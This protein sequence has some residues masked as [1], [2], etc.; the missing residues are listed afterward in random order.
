MVLNIVLMTLGIVALIE[1][2][3]VLLFPKVMIKICKNL[4]ALKKAGWWEFVI[5]LILI[6]VGMNI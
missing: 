3:I 4:K 6:L 1:S 2:I 5:A